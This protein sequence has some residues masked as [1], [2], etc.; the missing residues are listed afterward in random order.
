MEADITE[1]PLEVLEDALEVAVTVTM[2]V[3]MEIIT[4]E[5]SITTTTKEAFLI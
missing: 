2:T 4:E 3:M 1:A 5:I